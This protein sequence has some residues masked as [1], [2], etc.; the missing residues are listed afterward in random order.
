LGPMSTLEKTYKIPRHT[1]VSLVPKQ[2]P[3]VR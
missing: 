2:K 1:L 3:A